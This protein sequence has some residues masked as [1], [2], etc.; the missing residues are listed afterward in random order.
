[1]DE[2]SPVLLFIEY[3]SPC[4]QIIMSNLIG[5]F[6]L[7]DYDVLFGQNILFTYDA[8]GVS[9]FLFQNNKRNIVNK[10]YTIDVVDD[11]LTRRDT[12][13]IL[14]ILIVSMALIIVP[15]SGVVAVYK[16]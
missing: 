16:E 1:V 2:F 4:D 7:E 9:L 6:G 5:I 11:F 8:I 12:K 13:Y 3:T 15:F 14:L 10:G